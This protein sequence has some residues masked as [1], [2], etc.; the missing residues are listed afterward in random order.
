V[1]ERGD[2]ARRRL[3]EPVSDVAHRFDHGRARSQLLPQ[4]LDVRVD[5]S[6]VGVSPCEP[7]ESCGKLQ[8]RCGE[9][10]AA[11]VVFAGFGAPDEMEK[12]GGARAYAARRGEMIIWD[13]NSSVN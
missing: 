9:T 8:A 13:A 11:G 10:V 12:R 7:Y 5:G 1:R 4:A 2:G 3:D 6:R